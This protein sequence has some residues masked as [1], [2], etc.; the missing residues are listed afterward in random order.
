MQDQ[1]IYPWAEQCSKEKN[2]KIA[3]QSW[4]AA[5][6][7]LAYSWARDITKIV[8]RWLFKA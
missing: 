4:A 5:I 7:E 6:I 1:E 2:Y 8:S 3:V